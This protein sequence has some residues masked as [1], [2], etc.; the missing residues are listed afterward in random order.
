LSRNSDALESPEW[1]GNVLREREER[2][3]S[4][5]AKF[6][7]WEQAKKNIRDRVS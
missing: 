7:A 4:G 3:A 1:H 5:E 2:S 6:T